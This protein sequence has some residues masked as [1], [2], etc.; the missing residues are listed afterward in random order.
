MQVFKDQREVKI[1]KEYLEVIQFIKRL[2]K[3]NN[4]N[5]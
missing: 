1:L 4:M 5:N 2:N 3:N